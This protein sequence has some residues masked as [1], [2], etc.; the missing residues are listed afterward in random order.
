MAITT[1]Q[2]RE[3]E[4]NARKRMHEIADKHIEA[5]LPVLTREQMAAL[6]DPREFDA[7]LKRLT[8]AGIP[9]PRATELV[10]R[11]LDASRGQ[12]RRQ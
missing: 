12:S 3:I 1:E 6:D 5:R 8:G 10:Q 9:M 7:F 2:R 11:L 4:Q